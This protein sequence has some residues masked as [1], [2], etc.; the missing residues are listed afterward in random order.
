MGSKILIVDDE[1]SI[2]FTF[3]NFL[4]HAGYDVS[5]AADY[6]SAVSIMAEKT[7][8]LLFVDIIMKGKSGID[9]LR[10]VRQTEPNAQVIIITGAPSVETASEAVR[11]GALDYLVKPVRPNDLVKTASLSLRYK[12][13]SDEK[14]RCRS[15]V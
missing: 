13:F 4:A 11:L 3:A 5:A 15:N 9:L 8:D 6:D 12:Q 1:E 7:F 14:D 2:R 10:T